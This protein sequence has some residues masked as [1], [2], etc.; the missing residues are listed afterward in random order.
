M[1]IGADT[2]LQR[3][4]YAVDVL[5]TTAAS[6]QRS[7]IVEVMGR[8]CGYL[9]LISALSTGADSVFIPEFPPDEGWQER[10]CEII[11]SNKE[12]GKTDR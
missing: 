9:A 7:F 3:I 1:T 6:H 4:T 10:L 8:N 12:S 11:Q 2:A 5:K